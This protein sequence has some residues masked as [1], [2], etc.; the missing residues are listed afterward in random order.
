MILSKKAEKGSRGRGK[1]DGRTSGF[2]ADSDVFDR[3][4]GRF[5]LTAVA[6]SLD[7][8]AGEQVDS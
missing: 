5:F 7:E 1:E 3:V 2:R 6:G 8:A 4:V